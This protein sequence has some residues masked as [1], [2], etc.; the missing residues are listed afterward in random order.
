M[1][2]GVMVA[3]YFYKKFIDSIIV[4]LGLGRIIILSFN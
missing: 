4:P 3:L 1:G 2:N